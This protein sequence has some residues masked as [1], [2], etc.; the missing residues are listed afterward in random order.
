[1]Q[2]ESG[3]VLGVYQP[4]YDESVMQWFYDDDATAPVAILRTNNNHEVLLLGSNPTVVGNQSILLSPI[5]GMTSIMG[6]ERGLSWTG[7]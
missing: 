7:I 1:M 2:F 6:F 3:D 4:G 5:T